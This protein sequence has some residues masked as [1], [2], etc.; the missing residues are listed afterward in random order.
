MQ[1]P[2]FPTYVTL[3]T[4]GQIHISGLDATKFLQGLISNDLDKLSSQPSLYACLLTAQGKFLHDFIMTRDGD[5]YLL[6][7]EGNART[8]DLLRRLNMYKLRAQVTISA[9]ETLPVYVILNEPGSGV[10]D[11]RNPALGYRV[12]TKPSLP[13][14]SFSVWDTLR[15][16]LG[17]ADGSRDAELEKSTLEEL[18]MTKTAVSFEKGC[19]VGQELTARMEHRGLGKRHL[20]PLG[21]NTPLPVM[22][23]D[24]IVHDQVIGSMRSSCD[25]VGLALIRDDALEL[26]RETNDKSPLYLLG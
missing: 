8:Q 11:P 6:D 1:S 16:R 17:I 26:L 18:N 20:V 3:P 7:C 24:I 4:R 10:P 25:S 14:S 13:E 21:F 5:D 22:G 19:Y 12:Q 15:I 9:T 2:A 23:D